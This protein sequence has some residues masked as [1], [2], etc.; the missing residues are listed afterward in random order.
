MPQSPLSIVGRMPRLWA[1]PLL[2]AACSGFGAT[3]EGADFR[4][5]YMAARQALESGNYG[6]AAQ[7]YEA[8]LDSGSPVDDR[9]RLEYAH[10]LLRADRF[11]EAAEVAETLQGSGSAT[12]RAQA[13]AVRGTARHE[14]AA[15]RRA[16]GA[17]TAELVA[18]LEAAQSDIRAF[19][20]DHREL[21]ADNAM[22]SRAAS[23][24]A[25]LA[26]LR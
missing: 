2:L 8:L 15:T 5:D 12:I 17:D 1:L 24:D 18:L 21:D 13:R 16:D 23:I 6:D 10:T 19:L 20:S 7:R 25:E 22:Q 11:G 9:L 3:Q 26:T 4:G 14:A